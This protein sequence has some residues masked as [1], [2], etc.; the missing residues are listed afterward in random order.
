MTARSPPA[1]CW[2]HRSA[3]AR[4]LCPTPTAAAWQSVAQSQIHLRLVLYAYARSLSLFEEPAAEVVAA[5]V[6]K[7]FFQVPPQHSLWSFSTR[8]SV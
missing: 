5:M 1:A 8:D 2:L 4:P 6:L 3:I 7:R